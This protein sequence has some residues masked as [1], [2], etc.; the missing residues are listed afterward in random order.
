MRSREP[1]RSEHTTVALRAAPGV[2]AGGIALVLASFTFGT[3][4]L[5]VAGAGFVLLGLLVPVWV[6]LC[7]LSAHV[8]RRVGVSRIVEEEPLEVTIN[9]SRGWLGL[10]GAQ[11]IDPLAGT[12]IPVSEALSAISGSRMLELRVV[13][14]ARRRGR[15]LIEPP[16]LHLSDALGLVSLSKRG[17]GAAHELLVL[18]RTEP[19]RWAPR[20]RRRTSQEH[21][22]HHRAEPLG[23]GEI[24]GLRP[25]VPG[26]PASRIHWPAFARG[27]GLL[28]RRL[29][30]E[31]RSQPLI[32][33]DARV[34][35]EDRSS[36]EALDAAVRATASITLELA[37][38]GGCS[39]LL[40][41][42]RQPIGVAS[43]LSAWPGVHARL[44]LVEADHRPPARQHGG[45]AGTTILV[46][47][48]LDQRS[49]TPAR[50]SAGALVLVLPA[51]LGEQ[52]GLRP[53]FEVSG[54]AGYMLVAR[55]VSGRRRAA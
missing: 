8:H 9:V 26:S 13:T 21:V 32:V 55:A 38:G 41:G 34:D 5:L 42:A 46:A 4:P 2:L 48:R 33:L 6:V 15:Q 31:P 53:T 37:R 29:I 3:A 22:S 40:P 54:C 30:T 27:A 28:E 45:A 10:P 51:P 17:A 24:D 20:G 25:Y 44:A 7:A 23:A 18:P 52:L 14:R 35:G 12:G 36:Q 49:S 11:V 19:M 16:S 43:D 39:I 50:P 47:A 1:A